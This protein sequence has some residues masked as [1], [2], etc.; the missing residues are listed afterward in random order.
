MS[1]DGSRAYLATGSSVSSHEFHIIDTTTKTGNRPV[2]GSVD[3]A[4]MA[5]AGITLVTYNRIIM[6][7]SG[8]TQ[9]YQAFDITDELAPTNC[10]GLAMADTLY[11]VAGVNN[12][13]G[14]AYAYII[15]GNNSGELRVIQ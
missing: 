15:T 6:V 2:L 10:G 12:F 8:G 4:G 13:D 7:G 9:Q 3:S 14:N 1:S 5:P 11:G